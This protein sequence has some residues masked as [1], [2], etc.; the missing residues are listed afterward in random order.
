MRL[1]EMMQYRRPEGSKTQKKFCNRFLKPVMGDPDIHGNYVHVVNKE[2]GTH[3]DVAFMAHHD[4]VHRFGGKQAIYVED[5]L[6]KTM[7]PNSS[8][9]GADCTTGV[10]LIIS[11]IERNVPGVYV[12][13]AGEECGGIGATALVKD[14]PMWMDIVECAISFDRFGTNSIVTEQSGGMCCS[15]EFAKSLAGILDMPNLLPDSGGIYTDSAEYTDDIPE[16]T[17]ISVGYNNHHT[18]RE[19]Q[20]IAYANRLLEALCNADYSKL[21]IVRQPG[22]GAYFWK[23]RE[24]ESYF[25]FGRSGQYLTQMEELIIEHHDVVQ[26][27]LE[28]FGVDLEFLKEEIFRIK[29]LYVA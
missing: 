10:W 22:E 20:D 18:K 11:M 13:H 8:C 14:H 23:P 12:V 16:C 21:N 24:E 6:I 9:L 28:D 15:D 1:I 4:T 29:G 27:V 26:E 2:D 7:D 17:N 25:G 3:P 5:G 19:Y